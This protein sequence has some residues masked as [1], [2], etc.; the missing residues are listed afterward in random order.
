MKLSHVGIMIISVAALSL[1]N[2]IRSQTAPTGLSLSAATIDFGESPVGSQSPPQVL[3]LTNPTQSKVL[4]E[5]IITS[6]IDFSQQN[7]CGQALAPG[8]KCTIQVFFKPAIAGARTGNLDVMG[9]DGT[10]PHFIS[11]LG[12]GK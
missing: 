3:T 1:P 11:L 10:S 9:T 12:A 8:A 5:Q 6:G 2:R 7:D 4:M